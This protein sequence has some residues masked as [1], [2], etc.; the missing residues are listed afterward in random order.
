MSTNCTHTDIPARLDRLPWT[1]WHNFFV[2]AL[3]ITWLLDGLEVTLA[4]ALAGVI[5]RPETLG[6]TDEQVGLSATGYLAGAVIGALLFGYLTDRHGRK[7]LFLITLSLY[8]VSTA[9]TGAAWNLSSYVFFRVLTGAGIGG[10]YAAVNSAIDE[11]IPARVRGHVDLAINATF[12]L[13][14]IV[15]AAVSL[16]V[17]DSGLMSPT[18]GWRVVYLVGASI[19]LV[20]L[21]IRRWIPESPRWLLTHGYADEAEK[22]VR[23]IEQHAPLTQDSSVSDRT[24]ITLC[25]GLRW[26]EIFELTVRRY[27]K[28]FLLGLILMSTQAFFYNGIFFTYALVLTSHYGVKDT[29]VGWFIFPLAL[30]NFFGPVVLGRLFDTVGRRRMIAFTYALSGVLL[31]ASSWMFLRGILTPVSQAVHWSV[32]FFVASAAASSAYLTVSE[33]FPLRIRASAIAIFYAIGTFIGGVGTPILF[34][35][36]VQLGEREPLFWGYIVGA[37][38]M[39]VAAVFEISWGVDAE[40]KSLEAVTPH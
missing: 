24:E 39:I 32:I 35:H 37:A 22:I 12:W 27:P 3:G 9:L 11:L 30:G 31:A 16:L 36:L 17:L 6:L 25:S 2:L 4:G 21:Y 10:E 29:A 33:I 15:G 20:I 7:K 26:N 13:G 14:A 18:H 23:E 28:R 40:R 38:L 34:G 8:L 1:R 19:G 5:K